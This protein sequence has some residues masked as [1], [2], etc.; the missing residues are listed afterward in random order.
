LLPG[1]IGEQVCAM[2]AAHKWEEAPIGKCWTK[3]SNGE[4]VADFQMNGTT[5]AK[6]WA[7]AI[8]FDMD[9]MAPPLMNYSY[10]FN[11]DNFY[12]GE[13]GGQRVRFLKKVTIHELSPLLKSSSINTRTLCLGNACHEK[14]FDAATIAKT[15]QRVQTFLLK[16]RLDELAEKVSDF[17]AGKYVEVYLPDLWFLDT[18]LLLASMAGKELNVKP[19]AVKF[20]RPAAYGEEHDFINIAELRGQCDQSNTNIWIKSDLRGRELVETVGH[21]M[22]HLTQ[23]AAT[24]TQDPENCEAEAR[25]Y[26][27]KFSSRFGSIPHDAKLFALL[28][29]KKIDHWKTFMDEAEFG[30]TL[31]DV[32]N[33]KLY[34]RGRSLG[35]AN[36]ELERKI[37]WR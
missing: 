2:V 27:H 5:L 36:W 22:L 34:R 30:D 12:F 37:S 6:D 16:Q 11:P 9:H 18:T 14:G 19:A 20:F 4:A 25:A 10:A 21:E 26:G 31:I 7:S 33:S 35:L 29:D 15:L 13:Q 1:A 8:Q 23:S 28:G 24:Y 3:E 32:A 17:R